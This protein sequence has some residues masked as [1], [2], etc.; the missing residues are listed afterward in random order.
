M[1]NT[2]D[3]TSHFESSAVDVIRVYKEITGKGL[4]L[5]LPKETTD[6]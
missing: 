2:L 3:E 6:N 4:D 1:T 5:T